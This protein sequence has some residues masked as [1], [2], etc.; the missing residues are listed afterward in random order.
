[1]PSAESSPGLPLTRSGRFDLF[2]SL[3]ADLQEAFERA[4]VRR[5]YASGQTIY[6]KEDRGSEMFRVISGEVRLSYLVE[7]GREVFHTL[8]RP[9]D[10]FGVTCL[11]D[12]G[13]RPQ[14][15][16][17]HGDTEVQVLQQRAFDELRAAHRAFDQGLILLL[18]RD[19]RG[20][21]DRVNSARLELLPSRIARCILRYARREP[22]GE[23][24]ASLSQS[25]LAT[26][27]D[28][29]RQSVNKIVREMQ[30]YGLILIGYGTICIKNRDAL[31][32]RTESL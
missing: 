32:L 1:M 11:L 9:G 17:A 22:S 4:T 23:L 21:I 6:Q 14:F 8:Y 12:A 2:G 15:A 25:E 5:R 16:E 3:P 24:V 29:S 18:S 10:C 20:L 19:V 27:V 28:A 7:D 30:G 31:L 26:M 13:P